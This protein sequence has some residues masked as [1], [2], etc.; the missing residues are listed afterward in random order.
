MDLK[1]KKIAFVG[2][3]ITEGTYGPSDVRFVYH[4]LLKDSANLG[5]NINY[6]VNGTRI[7][8]QSNV[9]AEL[10]KEA[11]DSIE[12]LDRDFCIRC[13]DMD[14]DADIVVVFGGTNDYGHGDAPLGS[15]DDNTEYTFYGAMH[16]LIRKL[17][18]KYPGKPL[19]FI[20]PLH[21]HDEL[22]YTPGGVPKNL[23]LRD[24]V[25]AIR[26]VCEFYS[27]PVLDLYASGGI[28]P[29]MRIHRD[30][31]APDGVHPNDTGHR[32]IANKL[33]SFLEQL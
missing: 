31:Y 27:V 24:Y 26:E 29:V 6:G 15:F 12:S 23:I 10:L 22:D 17:T 33:Q 4:S 9:T 30:M 21:R 2:D 16:V 20:T 32:I 11:P 5:E 13:D 3:S 18:A 1:G 25:N 19:I 8:R 28:Q 14:D 7:A